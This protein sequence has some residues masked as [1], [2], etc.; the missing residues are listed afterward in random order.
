[1]MQ[2]VI[3][4]ALLVNQVISYDLPLPRYFNSTL[5]QYPYSMWCSHLLLRRV[6]VV[7][8]KCALKYIYIIQLQKSTLMPR[9]DRDTRS[10]Q[11]LTI[12]VNTIVTVSY[13]K[14]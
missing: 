11:I 1:M 5:T 10:L 8:R 4:A 9:Y 3:Y 7:Q 2:T 12:G 13:K 14:K 6:M